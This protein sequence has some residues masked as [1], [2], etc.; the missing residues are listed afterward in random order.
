M[1]VKIL[2][3]FF[4]IFLTA[5]SQTIEVDNH[6]IKIV[7]YN[8]QNFFDG[9]DNG[10]EYSEFKIEN[11][12]WSAA[13]YN[14]RLSQFSNLL[15]SSEFSSADII[16]FQEIENSSIL[17]ALLES[18]L[19]RRG[20][21]YYGS[22]SNDTPLSIGFISKIKPISVTLH[23]V[24]GERAILGFE[25]FLNSEQ[26]FIYAL[27]A[28][29]QIGDEVEN[30]KKR[31]EMAALMN[32]IKKQHYSANVIFIGDFNKDF[33]LP[34]TEES[35][36]IPVG[37][38]SD[39]E[40]EAKGAFAITGDKTLIKRGVY[41]SPYLDNSLP[42][43]A[44]GTY[45]YKGEWSFLDNVLLNENLVDDLGLDFLSFGVIALEAMRTEQGIPARYE[46][47]KG[48]GCSDHFAIE[49]NFTRR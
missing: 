4:C 10:K 39:K 26:T 46:I 28:K 34:Y 27:H 49:V 32:T 19:S 24:S 18:G 9:S 20:F 45:Y 3:I 22:V 5:C 41:Y 1:R 25:C 12:L 43:Q 14:K 31:K 36:F 35:A 16:F 7:S 15:K 33:A 47:E 23:S 30:E 29:S 37:Y 42:L 8:V 21:L 48:S 2:G 44:D 11:G 17:K 6:D 40:I 38:H 13:K